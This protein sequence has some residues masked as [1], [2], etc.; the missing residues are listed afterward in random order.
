MTTEISKFRESVARQKKRYARY[1]TRWGTLSTRYQQRSPKVSQK[2][3]TSRNTIL[4]R[5]GFLNW[6]RF[7][8]IQH[9]IDS[10]GMLDM[11]ARRRADYNAFGVT[12]GTYNEYRRL[13]SSAY[14]DNGWTFRDGR[15]NPFK[16]LEEIKRRGGH[17]DTPQ[18]AMKKPFKHP[19]KAQ[20]EAARHPEPLPGHAE[21]IRRERLR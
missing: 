12:F 20:R 19:T 7:W 15:L 10:P 4:R 6:E 11:R 5:E 3:Y 13:I 14:R 16:M 21:F 8:L 9:R 1:T 2:V 17:G 18:P